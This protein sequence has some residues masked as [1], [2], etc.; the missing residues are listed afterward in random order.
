VISQKIDRDDVYVLLITSIFFLVGLFLIQS[1]EMWRDE[2]QAWLIAR[3]SKTILDLFYNLKYE[4]HPGLWHLLLYPLTRIFSSPV[5]MQYLHLC[6]ATTSVLILCK[7]SPF[8][9][10]EK[11]GLSFSYFLFY[12][13]SLISRN[14]SL[15]V[16]LIFILCSLYPARRRN[17][18]TIAL[19]ALLLSHTSILGVIIS[20]T[21]GSSFILEYLFF[22]RNDWIAGG[23]SKFWAALIVFIFG[24]VTAI[25]Q[26]K[27]PTDSGF[28]TAWHLSYE[29]AQAKT[30]LGVIADAYLP[31]PNFDLHYWNTRF[32]SNS[33]TFG[34]LSIFCIFIFSLSLIGRPIAA[35]F[36]ILSTL[37]LLLFFYAKYIGYMRHHGFL[38]ICLV[39]A[40]WIAPSS[41]KIKCLS[42]NQ[43]FNLLITVARKLFIIIIAMQAVA[44]VSAAYLDWRYTFSQAKNVSSYILLNKMQDLVIISEWS[45][46]A[47]GVV[48]Y[49]NANSVYYPERDIFGSFVKFDNKNRSVTDDL[50]LS[51]ANEFASENSKGCLL[52]L[53]HPIPTNY[54]GLSIEL[55]F[56][57]EPAVLYDEVYYVYL[58][59]RK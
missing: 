35:L 59:Q 43:F 50:L 41:N 4:G 42:K 22:N 11:T 38:F 1:H 46:P 44:G 54:D 14:Y 18:I 39:A 47:I 23:H 19:I 33:F 2:L 8:T 30:L 24:V 16:L 58:A 34:V 25:A 31:V 15:G 6:I 28:A 27:P 36:Y 5:A 40:L 56:Q 49:L 21:L 7:F 52:V 20:I 48:G 10:Y 26:I 53:G 37:G 32:F 51:K 45:P 13:Y 12:E 9:F 29:L 57:S 3:D 17:L 55:V